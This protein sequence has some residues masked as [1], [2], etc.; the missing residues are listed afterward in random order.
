MECVKAINLFYI[1]QLLK[2]STYQICVI[3]M[4]TSKNKGT[5]KE[6][7]FILRDV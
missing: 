7:C 1:H 6:H 4:I 3:I 2:V 5:Q